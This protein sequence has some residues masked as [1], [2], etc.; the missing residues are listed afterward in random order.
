MGYPIY[1]LLRAVNR[2]Y[3]NNGF[4]DYVDVK[5]DMY[6]SFKDKLIDEDL[7]DLI[8]E[9]IQEVYKDIA[10]DEVYSFPTV[11]G[12]NQYVLPEDCDLRD[13]QEVTRTFRG[14][15]GP[16]CPPPFPPPIPT[17]NTLYFFANGGTGEMEPIEAEVGEEVVLPECEFD[18]PEGYR[19][20][21]WEVNEVEYQPGDTVNM[22]GDF[23]ATALWEQAVFHVTFINTVNDGEY[24]IIKYKPTGEAEKEHNLLFGTNF[25]LQ[26]GNTGHLPYT[27]IEYWYD[28]EKFGEYD[29]S[30]GL[31]EDQYIQIEHPA[32]TPDVPDTEIRIRIV[33]TDGD[34]VLHAKL[35]SEETERIYNIPDGNMFELQHVYAGQPI[36]DEYEILSVYDDTD[37]ILQK[38][39]TN[40]VYYTDTEVAVPIVVPD[41]DEPINP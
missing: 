35:W 40:E 10:I 1:K 13:I 38:D 39:F 30:T 34:A 8:N 2:Q 36:S 32:A 4:I 16:M 7:R 33:I 31:T 14:I 9:T 25:T 28:G 26:T 5:E 41:P 21:A 29:V 27:Y 18:P 20:K 23:V 6:D 3:P 24:I 37:T 17:E 19:F 12:Q 22:Q 11:P 15:R